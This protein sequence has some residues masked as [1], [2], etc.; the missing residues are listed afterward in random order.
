[1][2]KQTVCVDVDGTLAQYDKW[3]GIH[4]IGD[5]FPNA[6]EWMEKLS[7]KYTIVIFTCR[8][9][10]GMNAKEVPF[11]FSHSRQEQISYLVHLVEEWL[12][13]HQIPFDRVY[14]EQGKPPATIYFDD[15]GVTV[16][17]GVYPEIE[18][19]EK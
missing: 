13:K 5:P 1:M 16:K 9:H 19:E 4:E 14:A 8:T 3:R 15:R 11:E 6:K 12:R 17:N 10:L 7:K 18:A 2:A